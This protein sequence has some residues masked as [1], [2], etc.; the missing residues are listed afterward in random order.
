MSQE[1]VRDNY[2]LLYSLVMGIAVT[3]SYDIIRIF[4]RVVKHGSILVAVEDLI[5]WMLAAVSVFY[6][7]HRESNGQLRW[8][9]IL[10]AMAGMLLYKQLLSSLLVNLVSRAI[11]QLKKILCRFFRIFLRPAAFAAGKCKKGISCARKKSGKGTAFLKKK[12]TECKKM[13]KMVLCK[14]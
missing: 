10:G 2:F 6:M 13:L 7:M 8:F 1:I 4:R 5:F 12:L 3:F 9:A 11:N 14:Q